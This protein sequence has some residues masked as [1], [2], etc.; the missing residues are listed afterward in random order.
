[1]ALVGN[2][3][4]AYNGIKSEE[5][6]HQTRR[7]WFKIYLNESQNFFESVYIGWMCFKN[8]FKVIKDNMSKN[9]AQNMEFD[10]K[11]NI[12]KFSLVSYKARVALLNE[13][14][15]ARSELGSHQLLTKQV[16]TDLLWPAPSLAYGIHIVYWH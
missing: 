12:F 2:I 5:I 7:N 3:S 10:F 13:L 6:E 11:G 14:T 15:T 1:M 16:G 9:C 8:K 4:K